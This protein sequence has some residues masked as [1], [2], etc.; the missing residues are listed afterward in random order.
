[1]RRIFPGAVTAALALTSLAFGAQLVTRQI[2]AAQMCLKL[3]H[4][5]ATYKSPPSALG[6][7]GDLLVQFPNSGGVLLSFDASPSAAQAQAVAV[8]AAEAQ[9]N[10]HFQSPVT[11]GNVVVSWSQTPLPTLAEKLMVA[12]CVG[13][14]AASGAPPATTTPTTLR[15]TNAYVATIRTSFS[16]SAASSDGTAVGSESV[17][18]VSPTNGNAAT[19]WLQI[20]VAGTTSAVVDGTRLLGTFSAVLVPISLTE[21]SVAQSNAESG[22]TPITTK[23]NQTVPLGSITSGAASAGR[24][25]S[26]NGD[27]TIAPF[28]TTAGETLS[29]VW[30]NTNGSSPTGMAI[31]D[32]SQS[33]FVVNSDGSTTHGSTYLPP[34]KHT[35]QIITVGN[36]TI[37]IG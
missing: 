14:A 13:T 9:Q 28:T 10:D 27:K 36:W 6:T 32:A 33:S 4:G 17:T 25:F 24:N 5:T 2:T 3:S 34:G 23:F 26:G 21:E 15:F 11:V 37:H 20:T 31:D 19:G 30:Q 16:G 18:S 35:L 12:S 8:K 1:M 22:I 7:Q 29:W